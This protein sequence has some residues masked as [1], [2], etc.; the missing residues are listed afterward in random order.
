[1]KLNHFSNGH[2][3]EEIELRFESNYLDSKVP[4]L[5]CTLLDKKVSFNILAF[6]W[7]R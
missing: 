2:I 7:H 5:R 4:A 3:H 1:M 6:Y